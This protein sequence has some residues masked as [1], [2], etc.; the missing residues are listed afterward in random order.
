MG[1]WHWCPFSSYP[2]AWLILRRDPQFLGSTKKRE[3]L[4]NSGYVCSRRGVP[5]WREQDIVNFSRV[6]WVVQTGEW[7]DTLQ[8][9]N[10]E[11][12]WVCTY[13]YHRETRIS[14]ISHMSV[15]Q[16]RLILCSRLLSGHTNL[17]R[18]LCCFLGSYVSVKFDVVK[19]FHCT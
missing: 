14:P 3:V 19:Y 13:P 11:T 5:D 4:P 10:P 6:Q 18:L 17:G 12:G 15:M 7:E 8:L 1:M 2:H 9:T 16:R